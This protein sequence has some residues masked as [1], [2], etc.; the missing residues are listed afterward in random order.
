MIPGGPC[1]A[2]MRM[3]SRV[4]RERLFLR[5]QNRSTNQRSGMILEV[6]NQR[7]SAHARGAHWRMRTKISFSKNC[8]K[9]KT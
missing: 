1:R 7:F 8:R 3:S 2:L 9:L 5:G 4:E 6:Q